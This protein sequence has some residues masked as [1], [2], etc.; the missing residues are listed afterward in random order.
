MCTTYAVKSRRSGGTAQSRRYWY[1]TSKASGSED[2]DSSERLPAGEIERLVLNSLKSHLG[3]KAWLTRQ[4]ASAVDPETSVL[5]EILR[6]A[7]AWRAQAAVTNIDT[8]PKYLNGLIDRIDAKQGQ[9]SVRID[10]AALLPAEKFQQPIH[11]AFEISFQKRQNGRAKPIVIAPPDAP[12]PDQDLINLVADARRWSAELL[13]GSSCTIRQIEDREGLRSG[14]VSRI[15][16]LAWLA[17]DIS[18]AI[19]DGRQPAHLTAKI[20][21]DI[22]NLPLDWQ[23]QRKILGLPHQ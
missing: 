10:L 7:V 11:T 19:L 3:D 4:I 15:L 23:D 12:Q 20:L 16:P 6:A 14:S 1:Y 2:R 8:E 21:R 13:D 22:P 17:P 5:T 18:A 9:V